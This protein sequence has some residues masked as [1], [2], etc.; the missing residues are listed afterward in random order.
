MY[1]S[2]AM[3]F[4]FCPALD[5]DLSLHLTY[6][7]TIAPWDSSSFF[8]AKLLSGVLRLHE[9]FLQFDSSVNDSISFASALGEPVLLPFV[10]STGHIK[11]IRLPNRSSNLL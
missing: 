2:P 6:E 1:P 5:Y 7:M 10:T 3:S 8:Y 11:H 4:G 9:S